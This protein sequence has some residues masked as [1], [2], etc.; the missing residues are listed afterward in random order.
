MRNTRR[1]P[2]VLVLLALGACVV[3][4]TQALH[5]SG[6][7]PALRSVADRLLPNPT[8]L[9]YVHA[10]AAESYAETYT[11]ATGAGA[12]Y[13]YHVVGADARG[14]TREL[15]LIFFG[16]KADGTGLLEI[17]AKGGTGVR[18]HHVAEANVPTAALEALRTPGP[19]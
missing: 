9:M 13:V 12:N 6:W 15:Q 19:E 7:G 1:I 18:Y 17:E 4:A 11:D 14:A 16:A 5:G 2:R 10:P 3:G 8:V